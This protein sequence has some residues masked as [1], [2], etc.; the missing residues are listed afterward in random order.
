ME[1]YL[2]FEGFGISAILIL[3]P[4][5][6]NLQCCCCLSLKGFQLT[7]LIYAFFSVTIPFIINFFLLI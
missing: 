5:S 1:S 4:E 3:P 2:T 7:Q 6:W